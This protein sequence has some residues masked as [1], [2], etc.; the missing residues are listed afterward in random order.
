MASFIS[1]GTTKET[2]KSTSFLTDWTE[3]QLTDSQ[4]CGYFYT[5]PEL[6]QFD[7][8]EGE[9]K[10]TTG[11][12]KSAYGFV[13]GYTKP[14]DKGKLTNYIR[15]EINT[16]GEYAL[17]KFD[18]ASYTDLV[19][20]NGSGTAYFYPSDKITKGYDSANKLKLQVTSNG[21]YNV[22]INGSQIG[23]DIDPIKDGTFG[24]MVFFSVGKE[25][26]EKLPD[27]P[28]NVTYRITNGTLHTTAQK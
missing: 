10:K 23:G 17:Y 28:V 14:D 5:T 8:L 2:S 15:F 25:T 20:A 24:A 16:D 22:F 6:G 18:G 26:Q 13:F 3:T 19:G 12:E 11:Y 7:M 4:N 9:F 21:K 27:Q 1:C